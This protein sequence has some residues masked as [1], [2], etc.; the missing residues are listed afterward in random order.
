MLLIGPPGVGKTKIALS[1]ARAAVEAGHR[2]YSRPQST[3]SPAAT[4]PTPC[5]HQQP[6]KVRGRHEELNV[7]CVTALPESIVPTA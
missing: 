2:V 1:L 5:S 7:A 3:W 4:A 6:V